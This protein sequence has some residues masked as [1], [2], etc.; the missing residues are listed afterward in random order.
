MGATA[1][2]AA[3]ISRA[4][5]HWAAGALLRRAQKYLRMAAGTARTPAH[6]CFS[7]SRHAACAWRYRMTHLKPVMTVRM[8]CATLRRRTHSAP[9]RGKC[10]RY[11]LCYKCSRTAPAL[12]AA[13]LPV[14]SARY[15]AAARCAI[16]AEM[17]LYAANRCR[18]LPRAAAN[19]SV[20]HALLPR[21]S[22]LLLPRVAIYLRGLTLRCRAACLSPRPLCVEH[23]P[24]RISRRAGNTA[25]ATRRALTMRT[26]TR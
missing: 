5:A 2:W 25:C 1:S 14:F 12:C 9:R 26:R 17:P 20:A 3:V 21:P 16:R 19:T 7:A 4:A 6:D 22:P 11:A 8:T 10:L 13:L 15:N 23:A 18:T 24:L